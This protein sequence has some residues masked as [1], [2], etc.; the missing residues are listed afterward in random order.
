[1]LIEQLLHGEFEDRLD[2]LVEHPAL[3]VPERTFLQA[4]LAKQRGDDEAA[5]RLIREFLIKLP[6]H[7]EFLAFAQEISA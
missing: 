7:G 5:S 3:A 1:L 6:G 2:A 4:Q